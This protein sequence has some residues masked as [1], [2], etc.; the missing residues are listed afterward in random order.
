MSVSERGRRDPL[1]FVPCRALAVEASPRLLGVPVVWGPPVRAWCGM[2]RPRA[3]K[4]EASCLCEEKKQVIHHL[5]ERKQKPRSRGMGHEEAP[6]VRCGGRILCQEIHFHCGSSSAGKGTMITFSLGCP[7]CCCG[8]HRKLS[9]RS[10]PDS[11][12]E[13][14]HIINEGCNTVAKFSSEPDE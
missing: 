13:S 9:V 3:G 1:I 8:R 10:V 2:T 6:L 12:R 7:S 14:V 4:L 5:I 11:V